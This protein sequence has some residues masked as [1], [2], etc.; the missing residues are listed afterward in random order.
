MSPR[1]LHIYHK[2]GSFHKAVQE[3]E[4]ERIKKALD[5]NKFKPFDL[6]DYYSQR[7]ENVEMN[8]DG[9]FVVSEMIRIFE[10]LYRSSNQK[11]FHLMFIK[12]CLRMIY[13]NTWEK[14]KYRVMKKFDFDTSKQLCIVCCPRR[15]GKSIAVSM[16]AAVSA[17]MIAVSDIGKTDQKRGVVITIIA[18]SKRQST[19]LI[20]HIHKML[21]NYGLGSQVRE[22]SKEKIH[23][24]NRYG[25]IAQ[26]NAYPAVVSTLKGINGDIVILEEMAQIPDPVLF[27]V[28]TPLYQL[29]ITC[30]LGISTILDQENTMSQFLEMKDFNDQPLFNTFQ[31][32][33]SCDK[34]RAKGI[35]EACPHT[36][37]EVPS[38][39]SIKKHVEIRGIMSAHPETLEQEIYGISHALHPKA[40]AR[41]L[42]DRFGAKPHIPLPK[43]DY[44]PVVFISIDPSSGGK[45]S[46]TA[47]VSFVVKDGKYVII[48]ME[49]KNCQEVYHHHDLI[50]AH[51]AAINNKLE[52]VN[53]TKVFLIE[54]N[55]KTESA[56]Y[57]Q[58]VLDTIPKALIMKDPNSRNKQKGL[59]TSHDVKTMMVENFR[60]ILATNALYFVDKKMFVNTEE[61]KK[62]GEVRNMLKD[63]LKE[64]NEVIVERKN[65]APKRF[66]SGKTGGR[67]DDLVMAALLGFYWSNVFYTNPSFQ[68]Y[69]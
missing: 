52:F 50:L 60:H 49:S 16:Y 55:M 36:M 34:C 7:M 41:R 25:Q 26:I 27:E 53:S 37:N 46:D 4:T 59:F 29:E 9:D 56:T 64:F 54:N 14:N 38:W 15:A 24:T 23:L 3:A 61:G 63:Q 21:M 51:V 66:Y 17:Y 62:E 13:G 12:S 58:V 69:Y 48:G 6:Y 47:I 18:P 68:K 39:Q 2:D 1:R 28:V 8:Y 31:V 40:F 22:M 11:K 65:E 10:T 20:G 42:L 35:I 57:A 43:E 44:Y 5:D 19:A 45:S 30:F 32:F 33:L 67:K